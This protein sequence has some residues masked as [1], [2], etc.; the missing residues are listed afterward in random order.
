MSR[1][2]DRDPPADPS[3]HRP[4]SDFGKPVC[5]LGLA[6]RGESSLTVDD[7]HHAVG[8]GVDFLNWPGTADA[9]SRTVAELGSTRQRVVVCAQFE[10]RAADDAANELRAMLATLRTDY[11]DVLTF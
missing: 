10:A 8:R 3:F 9:F 6:S 2:T 5:R 4:A 1:T 11:I 7:V